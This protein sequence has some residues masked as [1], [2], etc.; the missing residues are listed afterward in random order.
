M[1]GGGIFISYRRDDSR[2]IAG[3]LVDRLRKDYSPDQ[4]F[5]DI[6]T[7]PVGSNFETVLA[8]RLK[9]CDV[10]IAVIG[11]SWAEIKDTSGLRR[12]DDPNDFVRREIAAALTR[13]DV[14]V[15]PVLV[16]DAVLPR[17]EQLPDELKPLLSRQ[18]YELRYERFSADA[19]DLVTRLT[20]IVAPNTRR[21][22]RLVQSFAG[23][24]VIATLAFVLTRSREEQPTVNAAH[25]A[26]ATKL[27]NDIAEIT[28]KLA[29][30]SDPKV[31]TSAREQF[32]ILYK[33]PLYQIEL[34]EREKSP[35]QRSGL[36]SAMVEFGR[37][38]P[39]GTSMPEKLPP[40]ILDQAALAVTRACGVTLKRM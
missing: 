9:I 6:D 13:D 30:V 4:L 7:I 33:G 19:D 24:V 25:L 20:A 2:D 38:L 36:E 3:R 40:T 10:L 1:A 23:A 8:H 26:Q 14:R 27:C 34:W 31:W 35:D 17:L 21:Y 11:P 5:L 37:L 32:W 22:R 28:G 15:I 29:S 18:K 39:Q 12:L 16:S